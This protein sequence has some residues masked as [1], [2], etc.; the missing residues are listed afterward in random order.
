MF[1]LLTVTGKRK[2][3]YDSDDS[4]SDN[5][6]PPGSPKFMHSYDME[7]DYVTAKRAKMSNE[8][9]F[10]LS[11]LLGMLTLRVSFYVNFRFFLG[12]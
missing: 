12:F 8:K 2:P 4:M 11:K 1:V 5:K 9:E 3:G 7:R 10:P 6:S